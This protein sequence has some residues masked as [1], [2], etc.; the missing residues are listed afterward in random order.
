M[1][2]ELLT[3]DEIEALSGKPRMI[4]EA[5]FDALYDVVVAYLKTQGSFS[6]GGLE[7]AD[8]SSSRWGEP[9]ST[10]TVVA[11]VPVTQTLAEGLWRELSKL[12]HPYVVVFDGG[13]ETCC[14]TSDGRFLRAVR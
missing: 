11:N 5:E 4:S 3:E 1:Q 13:V 14:V 9:G 12:T 2:P 8:F 10:M 6:D 7:E